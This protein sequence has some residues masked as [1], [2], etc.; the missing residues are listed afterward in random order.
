MSEKKFEKE[1]EK[2]N[3]MWDCGSPLY[4]SYELVSLDHHI[5]KNLMSFPSHH[6]SKFTNPRLVHN[7][8]D[9]IHVKGNNVGSLEKTKEFIWLTSF[10]KFLLKIMKKGERR[11][12]K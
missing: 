11:T 9:M 2:A 4:D 6:G 12:K 7:Y 5:N 8:E 3:A 10:N 1:E